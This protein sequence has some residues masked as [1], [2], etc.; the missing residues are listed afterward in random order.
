M[1]STVLVVDDEKNT[2][3]GLKLALEPEGYIIFLAEEGQQALETLRS[4]DIDLMLTDLR[5][6][7]IDGL[8]LTQLSKKVSPKTQV[9][10]L[11][12]YGTVETA[13]E[14]MQQGAYNYLTKPVNLN[15]LKMLVQQAISARDMAQENIA[16]KE[17]LTKRYGF[18]SIIGNSKEMISIFETVHQVAPTRAN[19]FRPQG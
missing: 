16:L 8:E 7:G 17:R 14:A 4:E 19:S 5:M 11:T 13:V 10:I 6:P 12:A 15:N 1:K 2:R 3:E 18:D 9:I